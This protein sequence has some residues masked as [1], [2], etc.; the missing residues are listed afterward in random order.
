[1]KPYSTTLLDT[2]PK[3]KSSESRSADAAPETPEQDD[4]SR[5]ARGLIN[6]FAIMIVF[7]ALVALAYFFLR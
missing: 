1:M 3:R 5:P 2:P 6:G 7:W 4:P